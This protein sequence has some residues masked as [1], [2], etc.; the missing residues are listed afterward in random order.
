MAEIGN[1][2]P[3]GYIT[4]T[5]G[6]KGEVQIYFDHKNPEVY[7][8]LELVFIEINNKLIPFFMIKFRVSGKV[9]YVYLEDVNTI[10]EAAKL[11]NKKVFIA[12]DDMVEV[13]ELD[14][15]FAD[16]TGYKIIDEQKGKLGEIVE[17][18]EYPQ[19]FLAKIIIASKEVLIPLND[20]FIKSINQKEQLIETSLPDGLLDI[21][22]NE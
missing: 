18:L 8:D 7:K 12:A 21:Y 1:H 9:G 14:F 16:L 20:H 19:Q 11:V 3:L 22:L 2:F 6:L 10:E 15:S 13:A 17:V 5:Q 4:K